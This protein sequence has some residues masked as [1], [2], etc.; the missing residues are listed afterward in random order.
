MR[1][2]DCSS[3]TRTQ[4]LLRDLSRKEV[5]LLGLGFRDITGEGVLPY[6]AHKDKLIVRQVLLYWSHLAFQ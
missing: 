2:K 1:N 5:I 4:A 3:W 6:Y